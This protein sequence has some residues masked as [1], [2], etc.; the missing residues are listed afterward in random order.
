MNSHD[1]ISMVDTAAEINNVLMA[2]ET[3]RAHLCSSI[4]PC[5]WIGK[6]DM[7]L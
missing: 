6:G 7:G 1:V 4:I 2:N 3:S 5:G